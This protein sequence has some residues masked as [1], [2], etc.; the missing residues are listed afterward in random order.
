MHGRAGG[1][2]RRGCAIPTDKAGDGAV[3]AN[4]DGLRAAGSSTA[5]AAAASATTTKSATTTSIAATIAG[6]GNDDTEDEEGLGGCM[7][8]RFPLFFSLIFL[9]PLGI[10]PG[11]GGG[12]LARKVGKCNV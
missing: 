12:P 11:R 5:A 8:L 9:P 3:T 4:I 2:L 1:R 10:P 6:R 7:L